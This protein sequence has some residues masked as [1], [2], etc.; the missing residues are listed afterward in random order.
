MRSWE[1]KKVYEGI[2]TKGEGR[3]MRGLRIEVRGQRSASGLSELQA[4][5]AGSRRPTPR[6][7]VKDWL[8]STTTH[9]KNKRYKNYNKPKTMITFLL[10][11]FP[12]VGNFQ[13]KN[14]IAKLNFHTSAIDDLIKV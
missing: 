3:G 8:Q 6:R 10:V 7:K 1:G 13:N 14:R 2:Q 11:C 9:K 4:L 5:R 12:P